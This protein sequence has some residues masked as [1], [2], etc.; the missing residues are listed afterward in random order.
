MANIYPVRSGSALLS[1]G[2]N[3]LEVAAGG[4]KKLVITAVRDIAKQ[5][6]KIGG[7][8]LKVSP[9]T[10]MKIAESKAKEVVEFQNEAFTQI[11]FMVQ[12]ADEDARIQDENRIR[13]AQEASR[14]TKQNIIISS[15]LA[16]VTVAVAFFAY[17]FK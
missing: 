1:W 4:V 7:A 10:K 9:E 14:R 15:V 6:D 5:A 3:I 2:S 11:G 16:V 12:K 17:R 13:L 8:A